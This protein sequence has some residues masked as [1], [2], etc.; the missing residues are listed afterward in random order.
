M[1]RLIGLAGG[2]TTVGV[3]GRVRAGRG[4]LFGGAVRR[5]EQRLRVGRVG[6]DLTACLSE[7][8]QWAVLRVQL[9]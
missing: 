2:R 5:R 9:Y 3:R 7:Q 1:W 8:S 4:G 6:A